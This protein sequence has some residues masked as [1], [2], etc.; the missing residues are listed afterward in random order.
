MNR[1][2]KEH[3]SIEEIREAMKNLT[4]KDLK[5]L[6]SFALSRWEYRLPSGKSKQIHEERA[7]K[8]L[9]D[10]FTGLLDEEEGRNWPINRVDFGGCLIGIIKSLVDNEYKK[11]LRKPKDTEFIEVIH[12]N[13]PEKQW[14][15]NKNKLGDYILSAVEIK[16]KDK[17]LCYFTRKL[18]GYFKQKIMIDCDLDEKEYKNVRKKIYRLMGKYYTE[19]QMQNH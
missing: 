12:L 1:N 5:K 11:F 18:N 13:E 7:D 4:N 15:S 9:N 17:E 14:D 3:A 8:T 19:Q 10:A 6:Y 16:L 2:N